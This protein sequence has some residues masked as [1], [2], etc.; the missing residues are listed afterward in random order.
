V[1]QGRGPEWQFTSPDWTHI[2]LT[3]LSIIDLQPK[4]TARITQGKVMFPG[5]S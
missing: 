4:A 3:V 2:G 5:L 1:R